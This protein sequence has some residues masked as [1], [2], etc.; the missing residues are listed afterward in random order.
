MKLSEWLNEPGAGRSRAGLARTLKVRVRSIYRWALGDAT[1]VRSMRERIAWLT[2]NEV[3][4]DLWDR[5]VVDGTRRPGEARFAPSRASRKT[6]APMTV[7]SCPFCLAPHLTT[8]L[9]VKGRP[10]V[11]CLACGC[12]AFLRGLNHAATVHFLSPIFARLAAEIEQG[13]NATAADYRASC[14][15]YLR[16]LRPV[17]SSEAAPLAEPPRAM[18]G[19]AEEVLSLER[20]RAAV[21][22]EVRP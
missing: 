3:T 1:P 8:K 18:H 6:P 15:A 21:A 12:R 2:K 4:P 16:A 7:S 11:M 5:E 14:A 20:L 13:T 19:D 22:T 17:E 10:F 9:D